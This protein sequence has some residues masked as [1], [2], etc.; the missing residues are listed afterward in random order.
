MRQCWPTSPSRAA[1]AP[2]YWINKQNGAEVL[3]RGRATSLLAI[4]ACSRE[5]RDRVSDGRFV[6]PV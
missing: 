3:D 6:K 5:S 4:R 2:R 1:Y